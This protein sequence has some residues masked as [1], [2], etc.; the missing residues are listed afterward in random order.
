MLEK[1][2]KID[3]SNEKVGRIIDA[4]Y[5]EFA[6]YGK[7]KASLNKILK[8]AGI[9][10]GVFYH[11]F[12]DKEMLFSY[13]LYFSI[14]TTVETID[15]KLDWDNTD[16]ILRI[17]EAAKRTL[18][19]MRIYPFMVDMNVK[20]KKEILSEIKRL[21]YSTQ[22]EKFYRHNINYG[23]FKNPDDIEETLHIIRWTY[24]GVGLEIAKRKS[25]RLDNETLKMMKDKCDRYYEV[26]T[27][28]FY[29]Q[30]AAR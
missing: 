14:R 2:S 24:K 28:A 17:S 16:L 20:F 1:F 6:C 26:L 15:N 22:R 5:E 27:E 4:A 29:K 21:N 12:G 23:L 13:L 18:D 8:K 11:Y 3:T 30:E 7:E 25:N 9:S 10:K 19:I